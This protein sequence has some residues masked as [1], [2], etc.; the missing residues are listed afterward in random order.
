M[1]AIYLRSHRQDETRPTASG[2]QEERAG[3]K[4]LRPGPDGVRSLI[5]HPHWHSAIRFVTPET[6]HRGEDAALLANRHAVHQTA[7]ENHPARWSGGTRNW[8]P[9][10][11]VWLN[12]E[13]PGSRRR[14]PHC[15]AR[16]T[17]GVRSSAGNNSLVE[18]RLPPG[19]I[20]MRKVDGWKS[21]AIRLR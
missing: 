19:Q 16:R 20:R 15:R 8:P 7:P 11:A 14:R 1:A 5:Q 21:L 10:G 4:D 3:P 9:V 2:T 6:R 12:P 17:S 18:H 13:R